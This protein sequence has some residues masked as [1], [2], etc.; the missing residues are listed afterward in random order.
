MPHK[1]TALGWIMSIAG[2]AATAFGSIGISILYALPSF[3]LAVQDEYEEPFGATGYLMV[4]AGM[5]LCALIAISGLFL[6]WR[7]LKNAFDF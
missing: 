2:I 4:A 7:G 5:A 1:R 6:I 3:A